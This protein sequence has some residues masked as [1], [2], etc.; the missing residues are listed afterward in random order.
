MCVFAIVVSR[1]CVDVSSSISETLYVLYPSEVL[2]CA[3]QFAGSSGSKEQVY[4][5]IAFHYLKLSMMCIFGWLG[6]SQYFCC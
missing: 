3:K 4:N 1:W 6:D 5:G 2:H